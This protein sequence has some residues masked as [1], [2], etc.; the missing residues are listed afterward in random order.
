MIRQKIYNDVDINS[1]IYRQKYPELKDIRLNADV[2]SITDNLMIS[3]NQ[4]FRNK[5]NNQTSNN[6]ELEAN[7]K[8]IETFCTKEI[9]SKYGLQPIPLEK[10]GPQLPL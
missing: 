10:I 5:R 6:T 8:P 9:L 2:N 3:C 1:E 4:M 7:G